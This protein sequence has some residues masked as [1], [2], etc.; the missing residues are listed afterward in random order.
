MQLI[1][2]AAGRGTRLP[3]KYRN[4][5]KCMVKINNKT[6]LD[7]NTKFYS[8]FKSKIIVTGYKRQNL[9]KFINQN[10]FLEVVNKEFASTNMVHS[11]FVAKKHVNQDVFIC[12][13]DIIFNKKIYSYLKINKNIL[14]IYTKWKALW[15]Q[16][17]PLRNI[18]ND[19]ED[20]KIKKLE[21]IS[22]GQKIKNNLPL[23]QFMGMLKLKKKD[24]F[25][26]SAFYKK[27][28][29]KKIDLT[30]FLNLVV[31][32]KIIRINVKK[33]SHFWYEIDNNK[34]LTITSKKIL[35][36]S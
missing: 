28:R 14:P 21:L 18:I 3:Q 17:M 33:T 25:K 1:L 22:I 10:N 24:F 26:L 4:L 9:K 32:K 16:R 13:G 36:Q 30:S 31:T 8:M 19:A 34:D 29:N 5:P 2:L 6:L 11:L 15:L 7:H 23:Y 12:Y 27:L 35:K 20:L